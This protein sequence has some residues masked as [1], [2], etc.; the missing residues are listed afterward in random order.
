MTKQVL[1]SG[2]EVFY[3]IACIAPHHYLHWNVMG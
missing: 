3:L 1:S 2:G